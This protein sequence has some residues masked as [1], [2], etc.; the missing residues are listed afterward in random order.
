L[1]AEQLHQKHRGPFV[2]DTPRNQARRTLIASGASIMA[3]A[4]VSGAGHSAAPAA[5]GQSAAAQGGPGLEHV[6][7]VRA[8]ID[9][10]IAMG[11]T[12]LGDRR[13]ITISGG[14]FEGPKMR[15]VIMPGGEDWQ[16][17]RPDGVTE[18]DAQYWIRTHDGVVIRVHN[19]A[20]IAPI[21]G[22]KDERYFRCAPRF[23]APLGAYDWLNKAIFVG[24]AGVDH[25]T[26]P[27]VVT[28]QFYKVT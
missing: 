1:N 14:T 8:N 28:L 10:V 17:S 19:R 3:G 4:L 7:T 16:V 13:V 22:S 18:L 11:K 20:L 9:P 12:P 24:T 2:T 23:E 21:E 26:Q 5:S 25:P 15:G 27:K 6:L